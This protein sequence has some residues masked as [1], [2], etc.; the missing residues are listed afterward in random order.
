MVVHV[1]R[2]WRR[3]IVCVGVL[4]LQVRH[5]RKVLASSVLGGFNLLAE[6]VASRYILV[7]VGSY[8]RHPLVT[9]LLSRRRLG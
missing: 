8:R 6:T 9:A 7:S 4:T 1:T 2:L 3:H 5:S